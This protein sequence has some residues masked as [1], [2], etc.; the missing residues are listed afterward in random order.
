MRHDSAE[1]ARLALLDSMQAFARDPQLV[2][3][4]MAGIMIGGFTATP[5][6]AR[7]VK[8]DVWAGT[9]ENI[10]AM[11]VVNRRVWQSLVPEPP[12]GGSDYDLRPLAARVS[13]PTLVVHCEADPFPLAGSEEWAQALPSARL[14]VVPRAGHFPHAER[15][16]VFFPAVEE[17]LAEEP[18]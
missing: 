4:E 8:A 14:V 16:E 18:P 3:R 1:N 12:S 7:R 6:A 9:P 15:P 5:K 2:C 10:R 17:F 11:A 13:A